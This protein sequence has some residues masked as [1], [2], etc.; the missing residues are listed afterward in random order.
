[1]NN[2][3]LSLACPL[4]LSDYPHI[5]MAHGSGGRLMN[6][7]IDKLFRSAFGDVQTHDSALV[8]APPVGHRLAFTTDGFVVQPL[9]FPGGTIGDLA[10]NGTV[11]DLAMA[12]AVPQVLSASFILEEGLPM[13]A[14][15][16][17]VRSMR[18]AADRAGV[19]IVTGD[20]KVVG[21]GSG[22][23][24]Y[25]TTAGIGFVP[26]GREIAPNRI[27]AG[28][29]VLVSGDLGRHGM[30]VMA[31]REGLQFETTI[32]SDCAPLA[33]VV[34]ALFEAGVEVHCLRDVTRGGL[35]AVL[36]E[37]AVG[38]GLP[39][40]CDEPSLPVRDGVR[41]ACE[42][43]GLDPLHVACEGRFC[44]VVRAEHAAQALG[45]LR[46]HDA[47][48]TRIGSVGEKSKDGSLVYLQTVLGSQRIL[49]MPRGELLPRIC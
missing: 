13:D 20:T 23:G 15:W 7:L 36:N 46:Q 8:P 45:V 17:I 3:I 4:P 31:A 27:A 10:V 25:I 29:A 6:H 9:V 28:D 1:M 43:L 44:A 12:G 49:D 22:G 42:I 41:G 24:V 38:A 16:Q 11:N 34:Q 48:A 19:K 2:D 35:A 26:D 30:A 37:L 18:L 14:L 21:R 32:E 33:A 5:V 47:S 39:I 40:L